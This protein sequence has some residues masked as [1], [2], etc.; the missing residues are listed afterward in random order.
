MTE[1]QDPRPNYPSYPTAETPS[2]TPPAPPAEQIPPG[3]P[4]FEQHPS[5]P[6]PQ[7]PMPP[8]VVQPVGT[9][10]GSALAAGII[11]I[12]LSALTLVTAIGIFSAA[13]DFTNSIQD[14]IRDHPADFN[15]KASDLPTD[16]DIKSILTSL[17]VIFAIVA[18]IGLGLGIAALLRQ[19]WARI[20]LIVGA[21]FTALAAIPASFVLVGLPWL[22]GSIAV[23]VLLLTAKSKAWFSAPKAS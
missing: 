17:G 21:S 8:G 22:A 13:N 5:F 11:T 3:P 19:N 4:G 2:P 23:I 18:L 10:P 1:P 6:V 15:V 14:Y 9:R 16:S 20:L 7:S 12:V